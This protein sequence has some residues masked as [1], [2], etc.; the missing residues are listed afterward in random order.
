VYFVLK[1]LARLLVRA[2]ETDVI[3]SESYILI[4]L[5]EIKDC[6]Y[7][8]IIRRERMCD[9]VQFTPPDPTKQSCRVQ[10]GVAGGMNWE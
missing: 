1:S 7:N 2:F 3:D 9:N 4:D 5:T 10:S 8:I 6:T